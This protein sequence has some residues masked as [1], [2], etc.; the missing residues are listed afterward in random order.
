MLFPSA[1]GLGYTV[2]MAEDV[3]S[4]WYRPTPDRAVL[5]LLVLEGFLLL[6]QRYEWFAF[7]RHK[8]W[9]VLIAVAAVAVFLLL[10]FCW[11]LAALVFRLRFQYSLRSL[12]VLTLAVAIPCKWLAMAM[13]QARE[14][15]EVVELVRKADPD[16]ALY[17]YQ[18]DGRLGTRL[19]G[20]RQ[21]PAWLGTLLGDDFFA[22]VVILDFVGS[23]VSDDSL[24]PIEAMPRLERL[25]LIGTEVSDTGLKHLKGLTQLVVLDL[26]ST[27]ISD[28][29]LQYVEGLTQLV[30]LHVQ[31]TKVADAGLMHLKRMTRLQA[32]VLKETNVTDAGLRHLAELPQLDFL[33]LDGTM[34]TDRG[35]EHLKRLP[36]LGSLGIKGTRVTEAGAKDLQKALPN[37]LICY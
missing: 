31:D 17:D 19:R 12:F 7:N 25:F 13:K 6:S 15:R 24:E 30:E 35:L 16:A 3:K 36:N 18:F 33:T 2:A 28:S 26:S 4:R 10:M 29:G 34:V 37:A 1:R 9:T 14:Q 22:H 21:G 27:K 20:Q 5:A 8:G 11:F 23:T 32:L